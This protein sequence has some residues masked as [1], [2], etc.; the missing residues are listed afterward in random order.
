MRTMRGYI[1]KSEIRMFLIF[2]FMLLPM[3]VL[4]YQQELSLGIISSYPLFIILVL[5]LLGAN[6]ELPV[7]TIRTK[8]TQ[9]LQRDA[10]TLEEVYSVPLVKDIS[11]SM[12]LAFNTV[13]TLNLGGFIVP[14]AVMLFLIVFQPDFVGLEI[15]LIMIV[16]ATLLSDF[17]NGIGIVMPDYIGLI[18][19]PFALIFAP[20]NAATVVFVSGIGGI[21]LG[22]ITGLLMFDKENKGSAFINLGGVGSFKAV[23]VTA[24]V[25]AL[26]SWFV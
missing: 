1:N 3:A 8:K 7:S 5:M 16:A 18:A 26:I 13:I 9:D 10:A 24:I 12:K 4:C 22:N 17:V 20:E 6:I 14:F 11:S 19:V 23:Y 25:A 15:M 21:L 2:G